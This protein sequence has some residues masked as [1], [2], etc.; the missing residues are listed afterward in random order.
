[1]LLLYDLLADM[2]TR[3]C[4]SAIAESKLFWRLRHS[5]LA[6]IPVGRCVIRQLFWCLLR[7]WPPAPVPLY[8]SI[9]KSFLAIATDPISVVRSMTATVTVLV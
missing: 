1:M 3:R 4:I 5:A 2:S 6:T 8:H 9:F 7:Y